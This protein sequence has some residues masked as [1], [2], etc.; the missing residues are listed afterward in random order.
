MTTK[1]IKYGDS[2]FTITS[3]YPSTWNPADT[4]TVSMYNTAGTAIF[5]DEDAVVYAGDTLASAAEAGDDEITLVTGTALEAGDRIAIGSDALGWQKR[6]VDSYTAST[7]VVVLNDLL[8]EDVAA[9]ASVK[10]LDLAFHPP[11]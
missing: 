1:T 9:G 3:Q 5:E 6:T 4:V 7:K 10:G 2:S 8:D 11:V